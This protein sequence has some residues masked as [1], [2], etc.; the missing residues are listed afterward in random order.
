MRYGE[1]EK[2]LRE[3]NCEIVREGKRHTIGTV[4]SRESNSRLDDTSKRKSQKGR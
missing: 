3:L 2:M 4:H 1:L